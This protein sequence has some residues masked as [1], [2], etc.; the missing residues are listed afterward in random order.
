MNHRTFTSHATITRPNSGCSQSCWLQI[1]DT[2]TPRFVRSEPTWR[3]IAKSWSKHINNYM[4]ANRETIASR[5]WIEGRR[6]WIELTDQR[7]VSFPADKYPLLA[8]SSDTELAQVK[9]RVGGRALR[10]ESLDEDVWVEDAVAGRFPRPL[11][12]A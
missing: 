12:T 8:N 1:T 4:D 6:I 2:E 9:L 11:A 10:W 5:C 3:S 7:V